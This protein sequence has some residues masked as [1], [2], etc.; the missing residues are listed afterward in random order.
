[1]SGAVRDICD[2]FVTIPTAAQP[3]S[4]SL[5]HAAAIVLAEAMRQRRFCSIIPGDGSAQDD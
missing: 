5:S 3:S 1:L 2:Q 4:L